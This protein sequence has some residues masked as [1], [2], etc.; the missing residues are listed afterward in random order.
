M[1]SQ[2]NT[3]VYSDI[4]PIFYLIGVLLINVTIFIVMINVK[5]AFHG[6]KFVHKCLINVWGQKE[7]ETQEAKRGTMQEAV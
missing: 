4:E 3:C 6:C 2:E 5:Y 1:G 7:G